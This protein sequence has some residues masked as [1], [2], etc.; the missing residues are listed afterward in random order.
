ML[1]FVHAV[2]PI[3][4]EAEGL[5]VAGVMEASCTYEA[6]IEQGREYRSEHDPLL[7]LSS[8]TRHRPSPVNDRLPILLSLR[9]LLSV[10][11]LSSTFHPCNIFLAFAI[12]IHPHHCL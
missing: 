11:L 9:T 10:L 5:S 1:P 7:P 2:P 4:T 12:H 6:E 8:I 3:M